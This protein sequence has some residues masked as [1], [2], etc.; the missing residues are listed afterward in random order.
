MNTLF[1]TIVL[2]F[3][4]ICKVTGL[5][6]A[7]LN[8]LAYCLGIP[9]SW[10]LFAYIRNRK[11]WILPLLHFFTIC[12][13]L[14]ERKQFVNQSLYFYDK[15]IATLEDLAKQKDQG[16]IYLSLLLGVVIPITLY[17]F[18]GFVPKKWLV[19]SYLIFMLSLCIYE[20]WVLL[21]T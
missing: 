6:Y 18:L 13:Y 12:L 3:E 8:I 9:F 11:L 2:L 4:T 5:R 16:Y 19:G 17:S 21:H 7:E 1:D 20:I 15:N 14:F 10:A